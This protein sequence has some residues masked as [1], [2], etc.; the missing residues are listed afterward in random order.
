MSHLFTLPHLFILLDGFAGVLMMLNFVLP[1]EH[2][3]RANL[4]LRRFL[5]HLGSD[6]L[7]LLALATWFVVSV[8]VV[9]HATYKDIVNHGFASDLYSARTMM[10]IIGIALGTTPVALIWKTLPELTRPNESRDRRL[11]TIIIIVSIA[12][13]VVAV[14]VRIGIPTMPQTWLSVWDLL[15]GAALGAGLFQCVL[16]IITS[17]RVILYRE[18]DG[19]IV[20]G[21]M[22]FV[23]TRYF[24]LLYT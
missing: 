3:E 10:T 20:A 7:I 14:A 4:R 15:L 9:G 12:M 23:L 22:W 2:Y 16:T 11:G 18:K 21:L 8:G 24:E 19:L 17:L 13:I 5:A 1:K 6:H